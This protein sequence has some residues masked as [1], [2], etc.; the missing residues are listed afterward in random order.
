MKG[1]FVC[2][3]IITRF[4][5]CSCCSY[6]SQ[7]HSIAG[8][9]GIVIGE[10]KES[11]RACMCVPSE[12]TCNRVALWRLLFLSVSLFC[13]RL[14]LPFEGFFCNVFK[15]ARIES[16]VEILRMLPPPHPRKKGEPSGGER[17]Q[18]KEANK[19]WIFILAC[20]MSWEHKRRKREGDGGGHAPWS[21]SNN[22]N[23]LFFVKRY[24]HEMCEDTVI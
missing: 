19:Q 8:I 13:I 12:A 11:R 2:M 7:K 18:V 3:Q 16:Q 9:W 4:D 17:T 6:T 10:R 22:T 1:C 23:K 14:K 24:S 21:S 5:Y 20:K 15:V